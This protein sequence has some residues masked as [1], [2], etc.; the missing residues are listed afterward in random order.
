MPRFLKIE[1]W[2]RSA[3]EWEPRSQGLK[4]IL[5]HARLRDAVNM[6]GK[7]LFAETWDDKLIP[8]NGDLNEIIQ[9]ERQELIRSQRIMEW[10]R[11]T[12]RKLSPELDDDFVGGGDLP[13]LDDVTVD[14]IEASL[15]L[16]WKSAIGQWRLVLEAR[17]WLQAHLYG[18][19]PSHA[20]AIPSIARTVSGRA[21]VVPAS[22]WGALLAD[23]IFEH[24]YARLDFL[25][26]HVP[27]DAERGWVY[28]N[29]EKLDIALQK[30]KHTSQPA[31]A[32]IAEDQKPARSTM[33]AERRCQEWLQ[34]LMRADHLKWRSKDI[35]AKRRRGLASLDEALIEPG[36]IRFLRPATMIG[37]NPG[38][39]RS[40]VSIRQ[41]IATSIS[42]ASFPYVG[43]SSR[44]AGISD[45]GE[46]PTCRCGRRGRACARA[47]GIFLFTNWRAWP[48]RSA[49][50]TSELPAATAFSLTHGFPPC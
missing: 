31:N 9:R 33:A 34:D 16:K 35:L 45:M 26:E 6:V 30:G 13:P 18:T 22:N 8:E 42:P 1:A 49:S 37:E 7:A 27:N 40:A 28:V 38:A 21:L 48:R 5:G 3:R 20:D 4:E 43:L 23:R 41:N 11:Q 17:K 24:D 12:G 25:P 47:A 32:P 46:R 15:E 19:P 50:A 2:G 39:N 10:E 29:R 36:R 14:T 44:A